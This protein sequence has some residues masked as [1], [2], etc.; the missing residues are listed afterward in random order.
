MA[1]EA[2][3]E[4]VVIVLKKGFLFAKGAVGEGVGEETT[5][6]GVVGVVGT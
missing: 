3:H 6:A 5:V 2:A 4:E 1:T